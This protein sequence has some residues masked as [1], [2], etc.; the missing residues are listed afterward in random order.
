MDSFTY[1]TLLV[2]TSVLIGIVV[3]NLVGR[4]RGKETEDQDAAS[5]ETRAVLKMLA[6]VLG[7]AERIA[8]N[9]ETHN[10]EIQENAQQVDGLPVTGDMAVIKHALLS[11][12]KA[13]MSSNRRLQE[14]LVCTRYRLEEQAQD[15]DHARREARTDELTAV[16]NRRAFDEKLHLLLDTSRREKEPF[17]LILA[18]L[19]Q[20]KRVNDAH[21]HQAG[22]HVLQMAG[23]GLKQLIREGDF[24]GRYGGDEFAIL[25]PNTNL[26]IGMEVANHICQGISAEAFCIMVQGGEVSISI[27][28]GVAVSVDDDDDESILLHADQALH[29]SKSA[30][31]NNVRCYEPKKEPA[32]V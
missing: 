21:G 1:I 27:S 11:H 26:D 19:D 13:L 15:I 3:G 31:R 24:V 9:V 16:A 22:D 23:T 25:L 7:A 17:V 10:T 28:M 32:P 5:P 6:E 29:R 8:S 30:G 4:T 2:L 18:D 12:V 20:F 14:D